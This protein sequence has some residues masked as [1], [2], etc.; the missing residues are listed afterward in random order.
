MA[1]EGGR[2]D[3]GGLMKALGERGITSILVEGGGTLTGSLF[4]QGLVDKVIAFI[5][6]TIIGGSAARTAV[7]GTGFARVADALR[8]GRVQVEKM[9]DDLMVTGYC[10]G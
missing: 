4:D 3:L 8:L 9:G 1:G 10:K 5:A 7:G 2:V 6:P